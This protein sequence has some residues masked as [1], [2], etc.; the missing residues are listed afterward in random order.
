MIAADKILL[1]LFDALTVGVILTG[2]PVDW[3]IIGE[4]VF[5]SVTQYVSC[6]RL[7]QKKSLFWDF[8][9]KYNQFSDAWQHFDKWMIVLGTKYVMYYFKSTR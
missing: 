9:L 4:F 7:Q 1:I 5:L 6:I 8:F 3:V 2:Y